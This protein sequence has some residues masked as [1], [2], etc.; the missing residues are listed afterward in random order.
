M[1]E[2]YLLLRIYCSNYTIEVGDQ[3]LS[4][5]GPLYGWPLKEESTPRDQSRILV[6]W[7]IYYIFRGRL[8]LFAEKYIRPVNYIIHFQQFDIHEDHLPV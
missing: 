2:L 7:L 4:P 3:P 1:Q 5:I 8:S 6:V